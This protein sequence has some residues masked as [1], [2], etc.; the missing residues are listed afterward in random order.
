MPTDIDVFAQ[1][2]LLATAVRAGNAAGIL[3]HAGWLQIAAADY[4]DGG[5]V[6]ATPMSFS[7]VEEGLTALEGCCDESH[8][9]EGVEGFPGWVSILIR[10][11]PLIVPI[12]GNESA[13]QNDG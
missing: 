9:H 8:D 6:G 12:I 1:I 5:G 2:R 4:M 11:L 13:N 7:S 10:L 3:R